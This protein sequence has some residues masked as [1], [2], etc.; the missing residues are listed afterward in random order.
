MTSIHAQFKYPSPHT[1]LI[2]QVGYTNIELNYDRPAARGRKIFGGLVPFGVLW[3]TGA[4]DA[5][6]ITFD[7]DVR[8]EGK[9]VKAGI[10]A[11]FTIPNQDYWELILNSEPNQYGTFEYQDELD[12]IRI[13]VP[14]QKLQHFQESLTFSFDFVPRNAI[15]SISWVNVKV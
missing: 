8:I 13:K 1:T 12:V 2:Q 5:T 11:L 3:P 7:K 14:V 9:P 4:S 6:N 10:Y 15:M